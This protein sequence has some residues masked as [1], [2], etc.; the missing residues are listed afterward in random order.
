MPPDE[1]KGQLDVF[2]LVFRFCILNFDTH[3]YTVC[4]KKVHKFKIIYLCSENRKITKYCVS[5]VRQDLNLNFET[6]FFKIR[7]KFTE[8]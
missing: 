8:L 3:L 2:C 5:F 7:Q 4:H 1:L 6:Q